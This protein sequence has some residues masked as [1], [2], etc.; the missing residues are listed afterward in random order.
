[1]PET[2]RLETDR[3]ILRAASCEDAP[4]IQKYFNNFNIIR[5]IGSDVPWPYPEDGA[6]TFLEHMFKKMEK[7]E[8][9]L[10]SIALKSHGN[11]AIGLI[12]YRFAD[13]EDNRGFW[14]A[15][16]FWGQGI[17]PEAVEITQDFVFFELGKDKIIVKNAV[18]NSQSSSVK[19][20]AG[21]EF[22]YT[23]KK[24]Y[25]SG[26]NQEEVWQVT[27]ENWSKIRQKHLA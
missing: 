1:M 5:Y 12:E 9:Y 22:L 18:S 11:E 15:E 26:D 25:L 6:I 7:D 20:K 19:V 14:L 4:A 17:M 10:W 8:I 16:P 3:L 27:A 13:S 2:P 23:Q 21:A 24:N